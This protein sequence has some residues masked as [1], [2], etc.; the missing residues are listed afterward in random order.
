MKT[1][2]VTGASKGLG[3]A[4]TRQLVGKGHSVIGVARNETGLS[5]LKAELG[6]SFIG[7]KGDVC[8]Q[9]TL[10][11]L[12]E[13]TE[14]KSIN[15]LLLNAGSTWPISKISDLD[16]YEYRRALE[17]SLISP[18]SWIQALLPLIRKSKGNFL[19]TSSS[20]VG[21][22]LP[23]WS[24]FTSAR[25]AMHQIIGS[26]A[27]EEPS[28]GAWAI[29]P[30]VM[31]TEAFHSALKDINKSMPAKYTQWFDSV[32]KSKN[33]LKPEEPAE[34]FVKLVLSDAKTKSGTAVSWSDQWIKDIK[35]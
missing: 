2:V 4:I 35:L 3:A 33:F 18:V 14:G 30:G 26:L 1:I 9:S 13:S 16:I 11:S 21:S 28:I 34:S 8:N 7:V 27:M 22:P 31:N 19:Y 5:A 24:P 17:T 12:L 10:E 20:V 29:E 32:Q 23:A 25:A 6:P 15:G